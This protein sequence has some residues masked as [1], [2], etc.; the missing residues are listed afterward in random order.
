MKRLTRLF[1]CVL[2]LL[3]LTS[4]SVVQA[5]P[6]K[7]TIH[8]LDVGQADSIL[9]QSP[10]GKTMLIDAGNKDD[11]DTIQA[12]LDKLKVKKIDILLATHPHE[13]HIGGM[14][15]IVKSYP[16]GKIYMPKAVTTTAAYKYLLTAIKAKGLKVTTATSGASI[17]LDN[18]IE[19]AMLAPNSAEYEDLNNYSAVVKLTYSKTSF[20]FTGDAEDVSEAEML[21][22]KYDLKADVLKLGHH[23][24]ESSTTPDFLKAVSPK[25]AIISVGKDNDY[26][27]PHKDTLD[28]LVK[29][30]VNIYRTDLLGTIIVTS[31][32][33]TITVNKTASQV[34]TSDP[35]NQTVYI[36][37]TG[38]AYH[39][40]GC[41]YLSNSKIAILLSDAKAN[42]Y[43]P[44]SI[45]KP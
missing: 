8:Y 2:I 36:T 4:F 25:Y 28:R 12:Y 7:L 14:A 5:A 6:Q 24:S 37:K 35:V 26:G 42:G 39:K 1:S 17:S 33:K 30:K 43:K 18:T 10:E 15:A 27:H 41:R 11:S 23:G 38:K 34:K 40:D 13:D 29:A 45:C 9:I 16:I 20:L 19:L 3:I 31:D 32:G 44:C 22:K 21:K